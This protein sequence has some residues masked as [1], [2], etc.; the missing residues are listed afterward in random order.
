MTHFVLIET[1]VMFDD[2]LRRLLLN[3]LRVL[4]SVVR[5]FIRR[6]ELVRADFTLTDVVGRLLLLP[7]LLLGVVVDDADR[8]VVV[9]LLLAHFNQSFFLVFVRISNLPLQDLSLLL[10]QLGLVL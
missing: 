7:L 9:E 1:L 6:V 2:W 4:V 5:V 8:V 10:L 3:L